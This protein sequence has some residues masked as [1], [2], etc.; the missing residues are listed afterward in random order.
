MFPVVVVLSAAVALLPPAD[1]ARFSMEW[2]S[3]LSAVKTHGG[4]RAE[5]RYAIALL[6]A[7]PRMT[8]ALRA[9]SASAYVELS[10]SL[11]HI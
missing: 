4:A 7:A 8:M 1:Q 5:L 2:R 9:G 10:L 3:E 11:I 6:L